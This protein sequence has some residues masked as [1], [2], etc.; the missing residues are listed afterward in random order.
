MVWSR[1]SVPVAC[2]NEA[3]LTEKLPVVLVVFPSRYLKE[4]PVIHWLPVP[5]H[6]LL[7]E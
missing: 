3:N 5:A 6:V 7:P 2:I 1:S 4:V